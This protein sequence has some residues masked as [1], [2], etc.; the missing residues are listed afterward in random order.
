[1]ASRY[2]IEPVSRKSSRETRIQCVESQGSEAPFVIRAA[3]GVFYIYGSHMAA[4]LSQDLMNWE[5]ISRNAEKGCK[6]FED[7]QTELQEALFWA[8]TA[9]FWASDVQQLADGHYYSQFLQAYRY[10]F[11][12]PEILENPPSKV[13][14][15]IY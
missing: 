2:L 4:A 1:M 5:T 14:E 8:R 7:V 12:H 9:T 13:V 11:T 10:L 3:D 6:L 15:D